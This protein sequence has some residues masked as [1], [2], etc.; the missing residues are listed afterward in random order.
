MGKPRCVV[1]GAS[2]AGVQVAL[3]LRAQGWDGD[4]VLLGEED[5]LPYQRPPLSKDFLTGAKTPDSIALR[6]AA[7]YAKQGVDYRPGQRVVGIDRARRCV[8]LASGDELA[9]DGLALATGTRPRRLELPGSE[10]KGIHYLRSLGDAIAIRADLATARRAVIIG[11]GYIG[12]EAAASLRQC[13]LE[14][15]VLEAL[16]RVL[17]RVTTEVLST[18]FHRLHADE[19]VSI[20]TG[21]TI[22]AL[23][24]EGSVAG[25]RTADG[26]FY[27][28]D[29]VLVG[30]GV[31]PNV[32]LAEAA[33]LEV[34]NGIRVDGQARTSDPLIVAAGD[35]TW[36]FNPIYQREMRLESVQNATD[37]ARVAAAT[38]CGKFET[39]QVLPW[40]WSDQYDVKLQIAGLAQGHDAVIVR[41]DVSQRSFAIFYLRGDQLLAVDA[42]NRPQ[43]FMVAKKL[44]VD[45]TPLL[46]H[47]LA[48]ETVPVKTLL[49]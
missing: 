49:A 34:G 41:G 32:E 16:P 39:Y 45:R 28:A 10:L 31:L 23:E 29:V 47:Q 33:G 22:R 43:E 19:G 35:C 40:F 30:I 26:R 12:L 11:G 14:V 18:F 46:A 6:P 44:I 20:A 24:G 13:G 5:G 42:I 48:D 3:S 4:I 9:Y 27:P 17:A 25:V 37:Q 36:H 7:L 2:H 38:L 8:Q 15:S 21:V 1:V